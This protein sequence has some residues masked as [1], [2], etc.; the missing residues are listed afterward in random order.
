MVVS[1]PTE[2]MDNS[3]DQ[4]ILLQFISVPIMA[5]YLLQ[6]PGLHAGIMHFNGNADL[7][8][9]TINIDVNGNG[10]AGVSYDVIT[11]NGTVELGGVLQLNVNY[12]GADGDQI[13]IISA[14]G[15][16]DR[17][18][19]VAGLPAG[20]TINYTSNSVILEYAQGT[21]W[22]GAVNTEWDLAG[23]WNNGVPIAQSVVMH[24]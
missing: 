1:I 3:L 4:E 18:A 13:T 20:W 16:T 9:N 19:T 17:F 24:S 15:I 7:S 2:Q 22:T 12:G 5:I 11:V 10:A 8:R 14:T 6:V 21:T 23:N